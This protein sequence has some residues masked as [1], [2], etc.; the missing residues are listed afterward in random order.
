M[1]AP[2]VV[3]GVAVGLGLALVLALERAGVLVLLPPCLSHSAT[4]WYCPGCGTGRA[5]LALAHGELLTAIGH[6]PLAMLLLPLLAWE[7]I[8]RALAP[9]RGLSP[10]RAGKAPL[11]VLAAV[12]CFW[13]LRN[14]PFEPF[15]HLAP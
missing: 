7:G 4:G 6:N 14:L 1:R 9:R 3:L 11:A 15:A 12:L 5:L 8:A 13:A 2:R 10:L